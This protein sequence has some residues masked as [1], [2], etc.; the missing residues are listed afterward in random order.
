MAFDPSTVEVVDCYVPN[1]VSPGGSITPSATVQNPNSTAATF[2]LE[3]RTNTGIILARLIGLQISWDDQGIYTTTLSYDGVTSIVTPSDY[4]I[5]VETT[6][7]SELLDGGGSPT[8]G[9]I[10][11]G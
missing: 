3:W 6:N 5:S 2:D 8:N 7:V 4:Q 9:T 10:S 11:P 1:S